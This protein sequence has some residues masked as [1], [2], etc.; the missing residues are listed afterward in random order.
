MIA[1][2][3]ILLYSSSGIV[4]DI[5]RAV[6]LSTFDHVAV[7]MSDTTMIEALPGGVRL[8]DIRFPVFWL[9]GA[10][11][12]DAA[13]SVATGAVGEAYGYINDI[14]AGLRSTFDVP[15]E[16]E[17]AQ[18]AG[19]IL[20]CMGIVLKQKTPAGVFWEVAGLGRECRLLKG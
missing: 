14:F 9:A 6:T 19:E 10:G 13:E 18:L 1:K 20:A 8:D 3:D 16:V 11:W 5:V 7:A 4:D 15:G 12:N 17:C 2:G